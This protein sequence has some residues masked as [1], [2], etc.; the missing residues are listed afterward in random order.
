MDSVI[1]CSTCGWHNSS[2]VLPLPLSVSLFHINDE[3]VQSLP[4][5]CVGN[6]VI[7]PFHSQVL[8]HTGRRNEFP[9]HLG[10]HTEQ[11]VAN[12]HIFWWMPAQLNHEFFDFA[13]NL[14]T[15]PFVLGPVLSCP[16]V[17]G[18]HHRMPALIADELQGMHGG[19]ERGKG[20]IGIGTSNL[21]V[22]KTTHIS[23]HVTHHLLSLF[24][25]LICKPPIT[26]TDLSTSSSS[27]LGILAARG[28]SSSWRTLS[29]NC[30]RAS[31]SCATSA[32]TSC[33][34]ASIFPD[35]RV[36]MSPMPLANSSRIIIL[37]AAIVAALIST[38]LTGSHTSRTRTC[39]SICEGGTLVDA[40]A[41][42]SRSGV[43]SGAD[44]LV[45]GGMSSSMQSI[46]LRKPF[47]KSTVKSCQF[48]PA[49]VASPMLFACLYFS[50]LS[51]ALEPTFFGFSICTMILV[52]AFFKAR[53]CSWDNGITNHVTKQKREKPTQPT[54]AH[55]SQEINL[56]QVFMSEILNNCRILPAGPISSDSYMSHDTP[57]RN[58]AIRCVDLESPGTMSL[59][60]ALDGL[61]PGPQVHAAFPGNS[62]PMTW[63]LGDPPA[64]ILTMWNG[65]VRQR[66]KTL[67]KIYNCSLWNLQSTRPHA[68]PTLIRSFSYLCVYLNF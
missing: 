15:I 21:H 26:T 65:V 8:R 52:S 40:R 61:P 31:R 54:W 32:F 37:K 51:Q 64:K 11:F 22:L 36:S 5:T 41:C 14:A 53:A 30:R 12:H 7:Q 27:W 19:I 20:N 44:R 43:P 50:N 39:G 62:T 23:Q 57:K 3:S 48:A 9:T 4:N 34:A 1:R 10:D 13:Q 6:N 42:D 28:C 24:E 35:N 49:W 63:K 2:A 68:Q 45:E 38:L 55:L 58:V 59:A 33:K 60:S 67:W 25:Q 18:H 17:F 29:S 66:S 46:N 56:S 16:K 47:S